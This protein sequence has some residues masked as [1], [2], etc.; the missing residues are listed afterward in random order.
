MPKQKV[1]FMETVLRDGQQSLIATRMPLSDILPILDKMDAAGYA[2]LEMWGGATFDACLRYLN[3]DPWERLRKIRKAVKHTKL[4]ML[5]RGQNLLGYKNYADDVVTDFVTK[6]V[7]NGI[8]IIRIFDALNDTRNLRTALEATKQ[9]GGHAQLAICYTTSDFHTID[10]F[11]KLAKDMAD[12]GADSIAIKDMAGILTPQKAFDLVTGIKQEISVPLEVHTHATAGMAEM[13][14]LEA[15]RAGAD[16]IDTA[17]SPFAGGTSQPATES[18]LV[19]LQD[20]GYPTDV[21]LSTVS[22]IATYFAPIRD[23]FRE[24]GQ[25]NP[26]VK[27]VEPKSLIYQ[28]PGGMLSNLLAQLKDQGQEALYGDVLKEVPRVRAD[29][30]Y[31]PLVTPLSQMVGTQS[32]MNVMSGERY[33]LIPNEIKDYVRGLYGRPPVAI[34]PEMVKKI[35]GDAPVVTQRPADLIKPQMP[36]FRQAI[37]QYAHNEEDVLSYALFPDQAKDFLGRREDPFYDVPEQKVSLS[38]EPTHD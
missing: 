20:L 8:D 2:S 29:L 37:A 19:A 17:V 1:Q 10:Y 32:L 9:A 30:G 15:V 6:S 28:V 18:M 11:I 22:D 16:I 13:T 27:D 14:Y 33:K 25:L 24:S 36:D 38:F 12:M 26:R 7:E 3:E 23:R 4:Q 34:A 21:D 35:I 5:L 31:P